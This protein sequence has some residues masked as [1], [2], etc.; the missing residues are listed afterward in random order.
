MDK[1][2]TVVLKTLCALFVAIC[3]LLFC[4]C[5]E[6]PTPPTTYVCIRPYSTALSL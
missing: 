6:R 2:I 1:S 4:D 5:L 3:F